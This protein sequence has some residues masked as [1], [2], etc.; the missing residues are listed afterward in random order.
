MC[1]A[2]KPDHSV[3]PADVLRVIRSGPTADAV[4]GERF[5]QSQRPALTPAE[6]SRSQRDSVNGLRLSDDLYVWTD[7]VSGT[8]MSESSLDEG[9]RGHGRVV[10]RP[11]GES[12]VKARR[13]S[14]DQV[15]AD[16]GQQVIFN[17][18]DFKEAL[19]H[20]VSRDGRGQGQVPVRRFDERA[21]DDR[22]TLA[23]VGGFQNPLLA[24]E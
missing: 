14:A 5:R 17:R 4:R 9:W 8:G 24:I 3:N 22:V 15:N 16:V 13:A 20:P 6:S 11:A 10:S 7:A 1:A 12:G 19:R 2:P 23:A 18:R 21:D